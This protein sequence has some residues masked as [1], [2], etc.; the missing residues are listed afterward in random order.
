MLGLL[1]GGLQRSELAWASRIHSDDVDMYRSALRSYLERGNVSF[2]LEF[3][4]LHEDGTY[5][6]IQLRATCLPGE[7]GYAQRCL[8]VVSD[9]T[10]AKEVEQRM[11]REA[12]SD[13]LTELPNRQALIDQLTDELTKSASHPSACPALLVIDLDRFKTINDGLGHGQGD[14]LLRTIARRVETV[15]GPS[16]MVA[17]I[18]S[19][20]FALLLA[21]GTSETSDEDLRTPEGPK[22]EEL[23][24]YLLDLLSQPVDLEG[25]EV[26]P[27]A[28]IGVAHGQDWHEAAED[29][30][31]D[32]EIAMLKAKRAGG[33]RFVVY[34]PQMRGDSGG[35]LALESDLRRALQRRQ[36]EVLYQPIMD[37][38]D[39]RIAGFEALIRWRHPTHGLMVPDQFVAL[40]EET[41]MIIP[42]G[43]FTLSMASLQLAQWQKFFPL[44]EPLFVSVNI[45]GRQLRRQDFTSDLA[46]VLEAAQLKPGTLKLEV[47][48]SQILEDPDLAEAHLRAARELGAGVALDDFGTGF[49]SLSNL[50]RYPFDTIKV[51][52][53]FISTLESREDSPVIVNSI[54][55]LAHDLGLTVIAEG[56]EA[57]D[58]AH[59]L[60]QMGCRF[61][62]GYIFGAPM[63]A[64]DAQ[65]FIAHHWKN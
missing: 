17:R 9:I 52:R 65:A 39:G 20:E 45:S 63:S 11:A 36:I 35:T 21:H 46:E 3:R 24:E 6:W 58:E 19:D 42:L 1:A 48:E 55:D 37:L 54:V 53:S 51:D 27:T 14:A 22:A 7:D 64:A 2:S 15:V 30:L 47:T 16:D 56:L 31:K 32:A 5:R 57:E 28:S 43:R 18:G 4:M 29:L 25:H 33:A 49:S 62:Q 26:F 50:Q 61:G 60:R 40:A 8:G 41:D 12:M 10:P 13:R 23:A 34:E 44:P 38:I 59:L